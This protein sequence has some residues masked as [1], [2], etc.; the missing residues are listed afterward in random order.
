MR[1][2]E[3]KLDLLERWIRAVRSKDRVGAALATEDAR[4]LRPDSGGDPFG[5]V[6]KWLA[7]A[8]VLIWDDESKAI[9]SFCGRDGD[10]PQVDKLVAGPLVFICSACVG[11]AA[12]EE[13]TAGL[14]GQP[15]PC[16]FCN[17][18]DQRAFT[19]ADAVIC[20]ACLEICRDIIQDQR[21]AQP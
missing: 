20:V 3:Q 4:A 15:L 6:F 8:E 18:G 21:A 10:S 1:D 2:L 5:W 13:A 14:A 7:H 9:C 16:A 19:K 12:V 11:L 17:Q